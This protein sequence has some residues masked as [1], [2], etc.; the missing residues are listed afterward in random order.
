MPNRYDE[1]SK[2]ETDAVDELINA[3][4]SHQGYGDERAK[5]L[6]VRRAT[7]AIRAS[8][9]QE[10]LDEER[11]TYHEN[12]RR[13]LESGVGTPA[14]ISI[15]SDSYAAT[16]IGLRETKIWLTVTVQQDTERCVKFNTGYGSEEYEY[17]RNPQGE[18]TVFR[19]RKDTGR[20]VGRDPHRVSF[21]H[22]HYYRDPHF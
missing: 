21:G 6:G 8:D 9:E 10:R 7:D 1:L 4:V 16:V 11:E 20:Q 13:L 19:F 18:Q 5:A 17:N 12:V 15:G 14:T 3:M 2:Q 22:R